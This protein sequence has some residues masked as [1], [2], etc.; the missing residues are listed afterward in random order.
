MHEVI[1]MDKLAIFV[2][3]TLTT[4]EHE[5]KKIQEETLKM[6]KKAKREYLLEEVLAMG[7]IEKLKKSEL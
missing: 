2:S 3:E 4:K 6:L 1:N 7:I 5:Q